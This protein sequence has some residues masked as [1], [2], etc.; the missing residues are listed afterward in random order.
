MEQYIDFLV[1]DMR[2]LAAAEDPD[3]TALAAGELAKA[4]AKIVA[5]KGQM[6]FYTSGSVNGKA[7]SAAQVLTNLDVASACRRALDIYAGVETDRFGVTIPDFS[8]IGGCAK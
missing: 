8:G 3:P 1:A 4:R 2:A 6:A 5:G 7:F